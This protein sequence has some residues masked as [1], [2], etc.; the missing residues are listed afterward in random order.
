MQNLQNLRTHPQAWGCWQKPWRRSA[1][2][3]VLAFFWLMGTLFL[4]A[5]SHAAHAYA[6]FGDVL[7][8][9]GF[10]H[11]RDINPDAPKG[12]N[13]TLTPGTRI[14]QY[15]KFNPFTL[16]GT[17]P[18]GIL[19]LM[20]DSLL[21]TNFE[22]PTTAYGLLAK[23]VAVASNGLSATFEIHPAARFQNGDP[24][25]AKD[26]Q[27]SFL[28]LTSPQA[29]PAY[30]G[31]FSQI[32]GVQVLAERRIRFDFLSANPELPLITGALPVFS[33]KWGVSNG[34]AKPFDQIVTD[35]PIVSGPYRLGKMDFGKDVSYERDAN[36]WAKDL[37][38]RRGRFNFDRITYKIYKDTTAQLEGFKAGEFDFVQVFVARDWARAYAG[39]AFDSGKIIK[40]EWAHGNAGDFQGFQFN[41]RLPKFQD[42][43]VRQALVLAMDYEWLNRQLFYNAYTRVR[44]YFVGSDFEAKGL[45]SEAEL[46]LLR[47]LAGQL[48]PEVLTQPVPLPPTTQ[49]DVQSG[50]TIR[51]HLRQAK[52]L[53]E[54]A[55]WT[56]R[57]GALRNA[58]GQA[59]EIEF[60]DSSGSM[61]RVV[62]P[63][64]K[65]LKKL[66]ITVRMKTVDFALLQKR[67]DAFEFEMTS[68]RI[69]G[70]EAPGAELL[71]RFG[72]AAAR[73]EG[74]SNVLGLQ[75]P[76]VDALL[77]QV[78]AARTRP[79]LVAALQALDRVL[80]H[81]HY[82]VPHWYSSVHR[83]AWHARR[84]EL[85]P[86]L[87]RYYQAENWLLQAGWQTPSQTTAR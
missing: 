80:R 18:P 58:Q 37:N 10:A 30:R 60:I 43:R 36:Y 9:A 65:H 68:A 3:F 79:E 24:V 5:P 17:A 56:Y 50:H 51:D 8:P 34:K 66:G 2:P 84:F 48:R 39:R 6:Q 81:G 54:E 38:V 85:P 82:T 26:V 77:Q 59:F 13:I 27:H 35:A 87:P 46:R 32:K 20:F 25:L 62:T 57:N 7:Y 73:T 83:V 21:T 28:M 14:T 41:L 71:E 12:G 55:G 31:Y 23:D 49:L 76:A 11:F 45:P 4:A 72:S 74:S 1:Q 61:G 70:N 29:A 69:P 15:D 86:K 19:A 44:G 63:Y 75:D 33:H 64:A 22:E 67:M 16:K 52:R 42:V 40:R 53:L 78:Q 47:P